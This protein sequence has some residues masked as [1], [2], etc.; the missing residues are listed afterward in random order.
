[1]RKDGGEQ[2][3]PS[4]GESFLL[5]EAGRSNTGLH[6]DERVNTPGRA[7]FSPAFLQHFQNEARVP[8]RRRRRS[9]N[10]EGELD[11]GGGWRQGVTCGRRRSSLIR[12]PLGRRRAW[13]WTCPCRGW[14]SAPPSAASDGPVPASCAPRES[15]SAPPQYA[16]DP[17]PAWPEPRRSCGYSPP[18]FFPAP[19]A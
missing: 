6:R 19:P 11:G 5:F 14:F 10:E 2:S 9:S 15:F 13:A 12:W 16:T 7:R 1:M 18:G 17:Q 4:R 3:G 8:Q